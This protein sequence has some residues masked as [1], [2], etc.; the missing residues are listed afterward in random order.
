MEWPQRVGEMQVSGLICNSFV[1]IWTSGKFMC[2]IL[3]LIEWV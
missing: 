1:V 2:C 3:Q